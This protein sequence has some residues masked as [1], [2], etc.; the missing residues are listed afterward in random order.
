MAAGGGCELSEREEQMLGH[1]VEH[2]LGIEAGPFWIVVTAG[3]GKAQIEG[4]RGRH[5]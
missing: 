4:L 5:E 2:A 3:G 1:A